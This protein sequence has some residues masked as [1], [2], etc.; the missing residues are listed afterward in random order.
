MRSPFLVPSVWDSVPEFF[1]SL[2]PEQ[3]T[4]YQPVP[5]NTCQM[6]TFISH[7]LHMFMDTAD[8]SAIFNAHALSG[9]E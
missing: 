8:I 4:Y 6:Q 9:Q 2:S 1:V 5:Y 7:I 3:F